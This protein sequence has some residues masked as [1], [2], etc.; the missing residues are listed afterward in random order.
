MHLDPF[1]LHLPTS[2]EEAIALARTHSGAFD[3][4]AGGTD[5]LPNY[6]MHLNVRPHLISLDRI[7]ELRA[8]HPEEGRLGAM[9]PLRTLEAHPVLA[10]RYPGIAQAAGEVATPL[11]RASGTLGGN[12]LVETRCFFFNQSHAWREALGYCLKAEGD[13]CHVVPQK[14]RCYATFSGDLAPSLLVL[15]AEIEIA[16][17]SGRRRLLLEELYDGKGDGIRR[18]RLAPGELLVRAALPA[19]AERGRASYSKLRVRPSFDFPELGVAVALAE[20][21]GRVDRLEIA[22]GGLETYPRRMQA[23]TAPLVGEKLTE[24]RVRTLA[25]EVRKS[26]RPVHNTFLAPDYRK[27]MTG[28]FVRRALM[29]LRSAS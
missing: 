6:K 24:D 4:L 8:F 1:E 21:D 29:A 11:V 27:R 23:Q 13:R 22:L 18:T 20:T 3:Y 16:G 7:E 14:E 19:G 17:T 2:V 9:V 25:E 26:V 12:L 10:S 28:V 15:G 5:L